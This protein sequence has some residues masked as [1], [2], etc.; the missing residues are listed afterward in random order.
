MIYYSWENI[1]SVHSNKLSVCQKQ[2]LQILHKN[3]LYFIWLILQLAENLTI[4]QLYHFKTLQLA[5]I[6][7]YHNTPQSFS[8]THQSLN[9]HAFL[10]KSAASQKSTA[11]NCEIKPLGCLKRFGNPSFKKELKLHLL[12]QDV[13]VFYLVRRRCSFGACA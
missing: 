8:Y 2:L 11:T 10:F 7:F 1:S 6:N 3:H 5:H 12:G 9:K 4:Q 13:H